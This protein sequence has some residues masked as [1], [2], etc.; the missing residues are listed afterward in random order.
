M[1]LTPPRKLIG[2]ISD[3]YMDASPGFN[4]LLIPTKK[5]PTISKTYDPDCLDRPEVDKRHKRGCTPW[6]L[7]MLHFYSHKAVEE[8]GCWGMMRKS[9]YKAWIFTNGRDILSVTHGR[10]NYSCDFI[11]TRVWKSKKGWNGSFLQCSPTLKFFFSRRPIRNIDA[12]AHPLLVYT[13]WYP[14]S[15]I[16]IDYQKLYRYKN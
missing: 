2:D 1:E 9:Y 4:P 8:G 16:H 5:R 15:T 11:F 7:R 10:I 12:P 3:K 6:F 13:H 14:L